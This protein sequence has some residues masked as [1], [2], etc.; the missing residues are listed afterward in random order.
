MPKMSKE[1]V[2]AQ[3]EILK[4][5]YDDKMS[6]AELLVLLPEE[7]SAEVPKEP[8]LVIPQVPLGVGTIND[9]EYRLCVIEKKLGLK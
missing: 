6:Y 1:Q 3:L 7:K 8:D 9:H 2:I 4:I 5:S